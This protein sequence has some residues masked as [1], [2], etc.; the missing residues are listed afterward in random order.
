[1]RGEN[2]LTRSI[3]DLSV[4]AEML[5]PPIAGNLQESTDGF[6]S[7]ALTLGRWYELV[8]NLCSSHIA[9]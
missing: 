7:K 2:F 6:G 8:P 4:S 1:V 9:D 3:V 5:N